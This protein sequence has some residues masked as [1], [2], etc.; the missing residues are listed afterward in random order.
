MSLDLRNTMDKLRS[1][2]QSPAPIL[3][4]YFDGIK[5]KSELLKRFAHL[6]QNGL[7]DAQRKDLNNNILYVQ[8]F[9]EKYDYPKED[10]GLALF[11]GGDNLFEVVHA[12]FP[13][14]TLVAVDH[15]AYLEPLQQQLAVYDRYLV[16]IADREKATYFT[17]Y[18]GEL[19][20][21]G[22]I[23]D[24]SVPQKVK[25]RGA[26]ELQ[27]KFDRHARMHLGWHF[28]MIGDKLKDFVKGKYITA[29]IVGGHDEIL[30][31]IEECLP[32]QLK[33]KVAGEFIAEPDE[34]FN[35]LLHKS[36]EF[37]AGIANNIKRPTKV[38]GFTP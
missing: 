9:L 36:Q 27:Q 29:V 22:Q 33:E 28:S 17:L 14:P 1:Y 20:N 7:S 12:H 26:P 13:L 38:Y 2:D 37:A 4:V 5:P 24:P 31:D 18:S 19:E 3:S 34:P 6:L 21:Q 15:S 30:R 11:S 32:K 23:D 35:Q 8:G 10:R 16:V 25:G